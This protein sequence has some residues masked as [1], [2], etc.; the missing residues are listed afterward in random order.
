MTSAEDSM[1]R[2]DQVRARRLQRREDKPLLGR[3]AA[4]EAANLPRMVARNPEMERRLAKDHGVRL[5]RRRY[6]KLADAGAELRLPVLPFINIG[7][8]VV[9]GLVVGTCVLLLSWFVMAE[10]F[11]VGAVELR[12]AQRLDAAAINTA[13]QVAGTSIFSVQP[14]QLLGILREQFPELERVS[15]G[16]GFP[17]SVAVL[18][19]E[20]QPVLAWEQA[21]LT[22]WVDAAG[23][24]FIS[25]ETAD[26]LISVTAL[27]A[28]P[29]LKPDQY[30][31][32]QLIRPE[33]VSSIQ[34][35]SQIAPEGSVLIYDPTMGFGWSDPG[36]WQAFFGLDDSDIVQRMAVY[37]S[38][39]NELAA[40]N[41]TP[42]LISV[43]QLH[44]PYYRMDY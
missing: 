1:R 19:K 36:G 24:A 16:V 39:L 42:T 29:P 14:D 3:A 22:V 30:G 33:M 21:G 17:A 2:A 4:G 43:A 37:R 34:T 9:S 27:E 6:L 18:V 5:R 25:S 11:T 13:L 35:L 41:L 8:R 15:V 38:M 28:P 26:D 40:R 31:R 12:G 10:T 20:R 7:W 32:H 44:A 23:V